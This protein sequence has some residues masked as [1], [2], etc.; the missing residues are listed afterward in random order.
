MP[1]VLADTGTS[2]TALAPVLSCT[3]S[4]IDKAFAGMPRTGRSYTYDVLISDGGLDDALWE[5]VDQHPNGAFSFDPK[6]M[7][8]EDYI[9]L[10]VKAFRNETFRLRFA[11]GDPTFTP[12]TK[13]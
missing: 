5:H 6:S 3:D 10:A 13:A 7:A 1:L 4:A 11:K 12:L 8:P 9:A 2:I